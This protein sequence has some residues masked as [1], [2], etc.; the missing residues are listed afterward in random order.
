MNAGGHPNAANEPGKEGCK[1]VLQTNF[2][3]RGAE[4][5]LFLQMAC[6]GGA[7]EAWYEAL[8]LP[9]HVAG[10]WFF[11]YLELTWDAISIKIRAPSL[12]VSQAE[13]AGAEWSSRMCVGFF[14][15]ID[16][17]VSWG[18]AKW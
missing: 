9:E 16:F 8:F 14:H 3:D 1:A 7:P 5:S 4:A 18:V 11:A 2:L 15:P 13:L 10:A 17:L 6:H 12:R